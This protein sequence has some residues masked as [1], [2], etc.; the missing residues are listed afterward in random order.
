MTKIIL[1]RSERMKAVK[2]STKRSNSVIT[3]LNQPITLPV[4]TGFI[5]DTIL[6]TYTWDYHL[7]EAPI[8][9]YSNNSVTLKFKVDGEIDGKPYLQKTEYTKS[10][11]MGLY[12]YCVIIPE[13]VVGDI[14]LCDYYGDGDPADYDYDKI[15]YYNDK[16]EKIFYF[17]L[18]E[19]E[20]P[21]PS[22]SLPEIEQRQ[23]RL[24]F[25]FTFDNQLSSIINNPFKLFVKFG[26][27]YRGTDRGYYFYY[28]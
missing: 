12:V 25:T 21:P 23:Q 4:P 7:N 16:N 24:T 20:T 10:G 5:C 17:N 11:W 2:N 19:K 28:P 3:V 1:S 18:S 15:G 27:E 14:K 9:D 22:T 13:V 6:T 26:L 8:F